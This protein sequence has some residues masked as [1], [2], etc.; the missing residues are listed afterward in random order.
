MLDA[1]GLDVD[2]GDRAEAEDAGPGHGVSR[3]ARAHHVAAAGGHAGLVVDEVTRVVDPMGELP[4][5]REGEQPPGTPGD[6]VQQAAMAVAHDPADVVVEAEGLPHFQGVGVHPVDD[7][8]GVGP[9]FRCR[10]PQ[11]FTVEV[12]ATRVVDRALAHA[13]PAQRRALGVRDEYMTLAPA[14]SSVVAVRRTA[15]EAGRLGD[16]RR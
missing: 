12:E 2:D 4:V 11:G 9:V 7:G 10:Y 6:G 15:V 3:D 5:D 14:G 16:L 1:A 13:H 8:M